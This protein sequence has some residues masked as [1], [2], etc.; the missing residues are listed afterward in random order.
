MTDIHK[1]EKDSRLPDIALLAVRAAAGAM[2]V[3]FHGWDKIASAY[4]NVFHGAEWGFPAFVASIGFPAAKFFA[5]CAAMAEFFGSLLLVFGF[6]TRYGAMM[7]SATMIVAVYY[8]ARNDGRIELA[9]LYLLVGLL[10]TF[11]SPG[12]YSIDEW[13]SS[14]SKSTQE[15]VLATR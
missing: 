6:F 3:Y 12:R 14:R 7:M 8:H 13:I 10:F 4:A 5:L 9:A 1:T 2:L 15:E 11:V